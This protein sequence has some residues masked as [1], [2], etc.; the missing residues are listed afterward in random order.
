MKIKNGF[1]V[2]EIAGEYI[3]VN[4]GTVE[5]DMTRIISL[6][7]S[8]KFLFD[9]FAGRDFTAADVAACL[10]DEYG[11][12]GDLALRDAQAWVESMVKAGVIG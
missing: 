8:A 9:T 6:N 11:I 7:S 1:K 5:I 10:V 2:R 4:Q 3:V 12:S